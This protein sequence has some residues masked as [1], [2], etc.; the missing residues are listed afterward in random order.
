MAFPP[1]SLSYG[2]SSSTASPN[3]GHLQNAID[4]P[5]TFDHSGWNVNIKGNATQSA[6]SAA[7]SSKG[8][9]INPLYIAIAVGAYIMLRR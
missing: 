6:T 5:F 3:D 1:M 2:E 4:I 8:L 9:D 7:G